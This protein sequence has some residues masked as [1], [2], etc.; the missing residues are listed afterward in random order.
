MKDPIKLPI[1]M[2]LIWTLKYFRIKILK[3][4]NI[5]VNEK[6]EISDD[7]KTIIRK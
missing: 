7:A 5:T 1:L 4:G 2:N 6:N 3:V